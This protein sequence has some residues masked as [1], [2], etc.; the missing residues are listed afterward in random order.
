MGRLATY[1]F[2]IVLLATWV[3]ARA[4]VAALPDANAVHKLADDIANH[5]GEGGF[6]AAMTLIRRHLATPPERLKEIEI[7][8]STA[9]TSA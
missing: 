1:I 6:D 8:F 5:L 4:Q 3:Q 9:F 7:R 2:S